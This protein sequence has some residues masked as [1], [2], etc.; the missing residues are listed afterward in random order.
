MTCPVGLLR[1]SA[2][3]ETGLLPV[4]LTGCIQTHIPSPCGG[5]PTPALTCARRGGLKSQ[6]WTRH[7]A[8]AAPATR[9]SLPTPFH[10]CSCLQQF[11][12]M[13]N[14]HVPESGKGLAVAHRV[15]GIIAWTLHWAEFGAWRACCAPR[16]CWGEACIRSGGGG[17][18][19][20]GGGGGAW[21]GTP[22][23]PGSP[24]GPRRRR[25]ENF[26]A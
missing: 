24:Y 5:L 23:L 25:A 1:G 22:V 10:S 16:W 14:P 18:G 21:L 13:R 8:P 26:E 4:P 12:A 9:P 6:V 11:F 20:D 7:E 17:G 15:W 2:V 19:S 3:P